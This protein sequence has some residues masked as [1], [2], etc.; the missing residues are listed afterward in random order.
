MRRDCCCAGETPPNPADKRRECKK[1]L[2]EADDNQQRPENYHPR[3]SA[4]AQKNPEARAWIRVLRNE[5][6]IPPKI[7]HNQARR[8]RQRQHTEE[9]DLSR[10]FEWRGSA[11]KNEGYDKQPDRYKKVTASQDDG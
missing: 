7:N 2:E 4:S 3:R 9:Q 8:K 5:R 1:P 10:S 6:K 11:E